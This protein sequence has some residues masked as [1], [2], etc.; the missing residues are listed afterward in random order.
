[1]D[2]HMARFI[3]NFFSYFIPNKGGKINNTIPGI[4]KYLSSE[5]NNGEYLREGELLQNPALAETLEEIAENG[6]DAL[7]KGR[8]AENLVKDVRDAGGI[9]TLNDMQSYKAVLRTPVSANV[10]GYIVYGVPPPSSGGAVVIAILRFLSGYS[11]PFS[12]HDE[13]LSV[14][15]MIEGM[16]HAF[17]IR[18][19]LSDPAFNTNVTRD[20]VRDMITGG[21]MESLRKTSRD[22][23]VLPLSRYGGPKW[24]QLLDND[25]MKE[26]QDAREG[27]RRLRQR[28]LHQEQQES[29]NKNDFTERSSDTEK[30]SGRNVSNKQRR[31]LARPFGYLED[32]GTSHMS[33]VDSDGNAVAI[34]SSINNIFGSRVYSESTGVLLGNTMDD[35]GVPIGEPDAYGIV[36]SKANF[37]VPGKRVSHHC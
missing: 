22:D 20:A 32:S 17:A 19:S 24:A 30:R 34:T 31:R 5:T 36:P 28:R 1:M 3:R 37:I 33:V 2:R 23:T 15:R 12:P 4:V 7:Y 13:G 6:A 16:R 35:F 21:Y 8:I 10:S 27:D 11:M 25:G 9:L 18:M 29:S 14:H 26:A